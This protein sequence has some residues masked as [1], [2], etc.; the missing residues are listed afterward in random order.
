MKNGMNTHISLVFEGK[1]TFRCDV[2]GKS[3][4]HNSTLLNHKR[5]HGERTKKL[6]CHI[7]GKSF[8]SD[9]LSTHLKFYCGNEVAKITH[10]NAFKV[11]AIKRA[12]EIGVPRAVE[13]L[14]LVPSTLNTWIQSVLQTKK[15]SHTCH[16]CNK[17]VFGAQSK[18]KR[19]LAVHERGGKSWEK[20]SPSFKQEVAL[21][22]SQNTLTKASAKYGVSVATIWQYVQKYSPG[23]RDFKEITSNNPKENQTFES[24]LNDNGL[25]DDSDFF[26]AVLKTRKAG[27]QEIDPETAKDFLEK[28]QTTK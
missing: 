28:S 2:C 12:C 25:L 9:Y 15:T 4:K 20:K 8:T 27:K 6:S 16:I 7:C 13:E 23:G 18:L 22:A 19:H 5:T 24:Y 21:F 26:E 1:N 17:K 11:A 10:S 3:F 14:N